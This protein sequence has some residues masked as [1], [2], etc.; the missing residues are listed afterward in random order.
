M[1]IG[2]AGAFLA[3]GVARAAGT[4]LGLALGG[5]NKRDPMVE[6]AIED[7]E[8]ATSYK[9][10]IYRQAGTIARQGAKFQADVYRQAGTIAE[11]TANS[12]IAQEQENQRRSEDVTSRT[13]IDMTSKN[14]AASAAN[15]T[16][17]A[18]KST[19]V[20]QNEVLNTV[21][22]EVAQQRND[23]LQRQQSI[24]YEAALTKMQYENAARAAIYSGEVQATQYENM[25]RATEYEGALE[26][27]KINLENPRPDVNGALKAS[28]GL[29]GIG[30]VAQA[31]SAGLI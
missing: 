12:N 28:F 9:A 3:G 4:A 16:S 15:G 2:I 23:S 25:A 24:A 27:F 18:S 21:T 20:V 31:F 1:A 17:V 13:L 29:G 8:Q 5:G 30:G 7:I 22:R 26:V 11:L 14:Y 10:G 6:S 19:M